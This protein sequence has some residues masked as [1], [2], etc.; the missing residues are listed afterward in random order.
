MARA[1]SRRTSIKW[2]NCM[3]NMQEHLSKNNETSISDLIREFKISNS[4]STFLLRKVI[5]Y[6]NDYGYYKWNSAVEIDSK[7][8]EK[9]R[10]FQKE[11]NVRDKQQPTL[12]DKP[13]TNKKRDVKVEFKGKQKEQIGLIR[14]FLRWI[15]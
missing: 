12:F 6:K 11:I 8:I 4:W 15:Y 9:F 3:R 7:L 2:L 1:N 10:S 13:K 14:K 5:V